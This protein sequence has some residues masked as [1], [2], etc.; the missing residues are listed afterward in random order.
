VTE[1][2]ARLSQATK[3]M[4]MTLASTPEQRERVRHQAIEVT[5]LALAITYGIAAYIFLPRI[6]PRPRGAISPPPAN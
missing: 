4:A 6:V 2:L 1:A 5:V 3:V